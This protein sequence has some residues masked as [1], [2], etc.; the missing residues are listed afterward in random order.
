MIPKKLQNQY[1]RVIQKS[2]GKTKEV[3][4]EIYQMA[5]EQDKTILEQTE[6][7]K[8]LHLAIQN[9]NMLAYQVGSLRQQIQEDSVMF[10]MAIEFI[11][12]NKMMDQF[13][14]EV[15]KFNQYRESLISKQEEEQRNRVLEMQKE[16]R[17]KASEP[18]VII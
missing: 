16:M 18:K 3:M 8:S 12:K 14:A 17:D 13:D 4:E 15:T 11:T 2:I 7:I 6:I 5:Q 1:E 9:T 10:Q